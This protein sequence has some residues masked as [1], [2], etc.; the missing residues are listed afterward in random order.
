[1]EINAIEEKRKEIELLKSAIGFSTGKIRKGHFYTTINEYLAFHVQDIDACRRLAFSEMVNIR[2][3]A[4][5]AIVSLTE[6]GLSFMEHVYDCKI[7]VVKCIQEANGF[8]QEGEKLIPYKI[9]DDSSEYHMIAPEGGFD[10]IGDVFNRTLHRIL[11]YGGSES[12]VKT[13]LGAVKLSKK[14]LKEKSFY[15]ELDDG[16]VMPGR[17]ILGNNVPSS[18]KSSLYNGIDKLANLIKLMAQDVSKEEN[19]WKTEYVG[20]VI[21]LPE[22]EEF[23]S[24]ISVTDDSGYRSITIGDTRGNVSRVTRRHISEEEHKGYMLLYSENS[25]WDG[26]EELWKYECFPS[27]EEIAKRLQAVLDK[28]PL[29]PLDK[30]NCDSEE[31]WYE[32]R[33]EKTL[34]FLSDTV[35]IYADKISIDPRTVEAIFE[36]VLSKREE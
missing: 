11:D 2:Y 21:G 20:P 22:T 32:N 34:Q 24:E 4:D 14:E 31:F 6:K 16:Y 36:T 5:G 23:F 17:I 10:S 33:D 28:K 15:F 30:N 12:D 1:M 7:H 29:I 19:W 9:S 27:Q 26:D 3:E 35:R 18:E 25:T 13:I 8:L